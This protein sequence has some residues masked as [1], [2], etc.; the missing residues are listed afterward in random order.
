MK[1]QNLLYFFQFSLLLSIVAFH[2]WNITKAFGMYQP[3]WIIIPGGIFIIIFILAFNSFFKISYK[4]FFLIK[5]TAEYLLAACV[6]FLFNHLSLIFLGMF[7]NIPLEIISILSLGISG[8]MIAYAYYH[9]QKIIVKNLTLTSTKIKKEYT[10]VQLSDI[11][12]GSNGKR[13]VQNI[14][15]KLQPL[16]YDF[17]IITGDLVDEDYADY[18]DLQILSAIEQPIYYIT[19]NHEYNLVDRDIHYFI[20]KTD[21]FDL[22]N[23]KISFGEL[24]IYGIDEKSDV[25]TVLEDLN[26]EKDRCSLCLLHEPYYK[27]M[28]KAEVKGIDF[29][30]SGHTHNGQFFP[31]TL[32]VPFMY[33]FLNGIYTL[34]NMI[35]YVSS[36]T[37][38]WGPK[39]RL[40]TDNEITLTSIKPKNIPE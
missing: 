14:I 32:L 5:K 21:I 10:F 6:I 40:G 23:K 16:K 27:K 29:L 26:V 22:N 3:L 9:G 33:R 19:G 36:G 11:H 31:L 24:D 17:V 28:H 2:S 15:K 13:E 20:E 7:F 35:V 38:T 1:K 30:F 12:I 18:R 8:I 37:G 34:G 4:I 39:M 25:D